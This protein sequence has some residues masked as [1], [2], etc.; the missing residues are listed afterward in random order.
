MNTTLFDFYTPVVGS[1]LSEITNLQ[2]LPAS[3][4]SHNV[5]RVLFNTA[6]ISDWKVM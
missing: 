1:T 3:P 2:L 5:R 6:N 4:V